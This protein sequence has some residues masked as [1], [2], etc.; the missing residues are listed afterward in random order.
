MATLS[1][2]HVL[3]N[4][5]FESGGPSRSVLQLCRELARDDDVSVSLVAGLVGWED[6]PRSIRGDVDASIAH[7]RWRS[8]SLLGNAHA[9][10]LRRALGRSSTAVVHLHSLWT[11]VVNRGIRIAKRHGARAVLSPRG[12][13]QPWALDWHRRRK[14]AALRLYQLR[15]LQMVDGFVATSDSEAESIRRLGLTQPIEVIPNGID[16]PTEVSFGDHHRPRTEGQRTL[17]FL[18]R[19]HP[20]K[21]LANLI[22]AWALVRPAGWALH[23]AGV[24]EVGYQ[25]ELT[26]LVAELDLEDDVSFLGPVLEH[27]KAGV[28]GRAGALVLP[29]FSEN[30]GMVVPEALSFGLPVIATHGTPW[31]SLPTEGCGWWVP[32]TSEALA[33]AI[34]ELSRSTPEEHRAM[35]S[36][37]RLLASEFAWPNIAS[38]FRDFYERIVLDEP[39]FHTGGMTS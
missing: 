38:R 35:S 9:T 37:A 2:V 30:F 4:A 19:I 34:R 23:I 3:A 39:L 15:N 21:G 6:L 26:R 25:S 13:L 18:G 22:S 11:P 10:S 27:R 20:I 28:Y 33:D 14:G 24:D 17:L 31:S 7:Y 16:L 29:S 8:S 5:S 36:A 1:V 32:P 12:T